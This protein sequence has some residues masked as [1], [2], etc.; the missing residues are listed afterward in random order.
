LE[1]QVTCIFTVEEEARLE[2]SKK[3]AAGF[4]HGLHFKSENE[5]N[6]FL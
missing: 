1:E 3:Q 6:M 5:G 4:L 2:T